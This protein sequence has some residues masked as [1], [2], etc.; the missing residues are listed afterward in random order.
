[1]LRIG[2]RPTRVTY[3]VLINAYALAAEAQN[4]ADRAQNMAYKA[5]GSRHRQRDA[6]GGRAG[7]RQ[8]KEEK[9]E[10]GEGGGGARK[11]VGS[12][13]LLEKAI[14]VLE[15]MQKAG[16]YPDVWTYNTLLNACAKSAASTRKSPRK[17][18]K[19]VQLARSRWA[20]GGRV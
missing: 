4:A 3:N 11:G 18:V 14:G 5:P 20:L 12:G 15:F 19:V 7:G 8:G 17:A 2:I 13:D 16:V 6:R 1:M 10:E 9:D